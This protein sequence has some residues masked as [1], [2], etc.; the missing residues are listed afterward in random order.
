MGAKSGAEYIR[1]LDSRNLDVW[2]HGQKVEGKISEHPAFKNVIKSM[3]ALYDMQFN[4]DT[5]GEMT[6]VENGERYGMSFLV[7][8]SVEDLVRRR[9]MMKRWA[10]FSG[11]M[12]GRSADYLNS[13]VMAIGQAPG[14]FAQND[15]RFAENAKDY[16]EF[17]RTND[18]SLTHTL[19]NPQANRGVGASQQSDPYLAARVV[20]KN[21]EGVII[22]GARLLATQGPITDEILV[23]PSTLLKGTDEDN[24]Y[25]F[26]FV[27][28]CDTPGL[29][30]ICRETFDYGFSHHDHPLG[31]RFEEM[32]A[33]VVFDDVIVP[34]NRVFLLENAKLCNNLHF[35]THAT[36]HMTHQVLQK[37]IAKAEFILGIVQ[38][39]I[40]TIGISQFQHVQE[41]AAEVILAVETMKAFVRASEADAKLDEFGMMTPAWWPLN[42]A[43]NIFPRTYPRLIEIV[44]LLG[45]SGLMAIP[46]E[47]DMKSPIEP[48]ISK[49][50]V[51]KNAPADDRLR[52]FRLAWDASLSAF[53]SRQVLY[54]RYFF[55]DPVRMYGNVYQSY[56][57]QPFVDRVQEFLHRTSDE[58]VQA[59]R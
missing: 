25:S 8:K 54:E 31:S 14:Y 12:M 6:F 33:I 55:G 52:L 58:R 50:L 37:N 19:I 46:G 45:A 1:N 40:D 39:I 57:K 32:D 5:Q 22:R 7:P 47:A 43:R 41:K 44:Q 13:A 38:S 26:A 24:P 18:I 36:H 48:D 27:I 42:A 20:E 35:G 11:G 2:I 49:Y 3:A 56:D 4:P 51:A 28:P 21:S 59:L 30:F 17:A 34:W 9:K 10:D 15:A 53:G 16:Y 29:R 23:F